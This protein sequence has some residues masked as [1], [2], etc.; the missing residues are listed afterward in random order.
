MCPHVSQKDSAQKLTHSTR[1]HVPPSSVTRLHMPGF[2][3]LMSALGDVII[4]TSSADVTRQSAD[5]IV[6]QDVDQTVDLR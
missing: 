5:V 6:D 4:A 1:R 3:L 2:L